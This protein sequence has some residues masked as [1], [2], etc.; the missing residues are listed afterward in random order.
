MPGSSGCGK[1]TL[2]AGLVG[3][4]FTCLAD[5]IAVLTDS[6]VRLRPMPV[7]IA[8]KQGSWPP[9]A[10]LQAHLQAHL[11]SL[12]EYALAEGS[13]VKYLSPADIRAQFLSEF[14]V[15]MSSLV[16]PR[17]VSWPKNELRRISKGDAFGKLFAAGHDLKGPFSESRVRIVTDWLRETPCFELEFSDLD[18]AIGRI[19]GLLS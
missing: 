17:Y 9:L 15:E 2:T 1:S 16:F 11:D 3:A 8:L 10:R 19:A 4:G 13:S 7:R 12:P 6:P 18:A 14:P 5:D